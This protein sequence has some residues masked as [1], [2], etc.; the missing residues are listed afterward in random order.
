MSANSKYDYY[1]KG[2]ATAF[3][4]QEKEGLSLFKSK[5]ST[6]HSGELFTDFSFRNNG[7]VP[8]NIDDKGR[9]AIT[10]T[11]TDKYKFKVPS[12]RNVGYTAPYMHDG[13]YHSLEEVLDHYA[14]SVHKSPTLDPIFQKADG[15]TGINLTASEKQS[16]IAFLRTLSD[17]QFIK[18]AKFADPGVGTSF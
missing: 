11:E 9:F 13:R 5:C 10:G 17:E 14:D 2:D 15:K 6:C 12:L 3:N 8:V 4:A 18:E 1:V 16:I 7:L